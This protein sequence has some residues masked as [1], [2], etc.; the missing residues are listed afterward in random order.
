MRIL[1]LK[2][3]TPWQDQDFGGRRLG[4]SVCVQRYG[5]FGDMLQVSSVLPGLKEQGY[6]VTVNVTEIG[7][8]MLRNDPFIDV[9][10][11][12]KTDQVPNHELG[13][14][15]TKLSKCFDK[16]IM[17][18]ES[19]EGA[20]LALPG[21]RESAWHPEFRRMIM[22]TVDYMEATHAIAEVPLPPKTKFYPNSVEKSWAKQQRKKLG[23]KNFVILWTLSG[24][25]VHKT[26][27]HLDLILARLLC[28][29]ENVKVVLVG[30]ALC[31]MLEAQW[32]KE[33]RV[34]CKSG[35][36]SIRQTLAF[37]KR[38]DMVVGPETGVM[39]SV[40]MGEMF[41]LLM[42]SHSSKN[43]IG[44]NWVN[45]IALTPHETPCYPCHILHGGFDLCCKDEVFGTALCASNTDPEEVW[46]VIKSEIGEPDHE[47]DVLSS[48]SEIS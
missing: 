13:L 42:L 2:E 15:W 23:G 10:F 36:W 45:T 19:V 24:S 14:Y 26:W 22:G 3:G 18:S 11:V 7:L 33:E 6:Q 43:N 25:S 47:F 20:L 32:E 31:Q 5:G 41:K 16:F 44:G 34:L 17:L 8:E 9:A 21:R 27:P 12:Q 46:E 4:K 40:S 1:Y 39:N 48:V 37:A 35:K 30:D 28:S 29:Y 38:C